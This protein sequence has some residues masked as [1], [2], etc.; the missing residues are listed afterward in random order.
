MRKSVI[1]QIFGDNRAPIKEVLDADFADLK[2]DIDGLTQEMRDSYTAPKND[3]D[4]AAIGKLI[5]RARALAKRADENR[6]AEKA[7]ILEAGRD[8]DGWFKDTLASL[9]KGSEA[10]QGLADNYVRQ[11]DAEARAKAER[12]AEEL[13]RKEKA[14]REKADAAKTA[15]GAGRAEAR[16]ENLAAKAEQAEETATAR[17]ADLTRS[18]VGG[19]TASARGTWTARITDYQAAIKP[20][21]ALGHFLKQDHIEAALNSLAK[22]QKAAA[23]WPGVTFSQETKANFRR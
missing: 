13:R 21:G 17:T 20:L 3:D 22:T 15:A 18:R 6:T 1:D 2:A 16:A 5:I 23:E 4:Q 10:L 9:V 19:V 14:E 8:L 11:K 12:E 7:P